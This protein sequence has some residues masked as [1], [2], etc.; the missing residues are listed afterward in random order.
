VREALSNV[1]ALAVLAS[2]VMLI[3]PLPP[4]LLDLLLAFD[5]MFAAGVLV[6]ALSIHDPLELAAFPSLLL[7]T[8]LFRLSLDVSATR[9]ILTQ[10]DVPGGVGTVIPAF[11][12]FVT[13]GNL[14][15][16]ILMLT[17]LI[18]VQLVV[19]TNGAQRVAEVAARFTLDAM[20]GKQMAIDADLH[21]GLIDAGTARQRRKAVQAEADFYGAMDGAGKFVRGDAIAAVVIVVVNVIAGTA[22]GV[23]GKHMDLAAAVATYPV[24]SVGNAL[25]TTLPAF[26]LSTAMGIMVTRAASETTLGVDLVRQLCAQ[27]HA[28]NAVG[29][30]MLALAVVPGLP[31]TAFA[32][33]GGTSLAGARLAR[34]AQRR[35][36]QAAYRI[37]EDRRRSETH[38]PEHAVSL[39]GLDV[40]S[41]H[42]GEALL[43]LL[44]PPACEELLGR[45]ALVRRRIALELGI[46]MPGV[47]VSDDLQLPARG[48]AIRLRDRTVAQGLLHPDRPLVVGAPEALT[49]I[50]GERVLDPAI[51]LQAVWPTNP[52]PGDDSAGDLVAVDP[53]AIVAT[54]LD[55]VV[56]VHAAA[57][58]GRQEVQQLLDT[59]KTAQ[60]AAVKGIVPETVSLA[61]VQRVLQHLVREEVSVRDMATII[62]TLAEEAETSRDPSRIGEAV[63][64]RLAAAI[65]AALADE[66][67]VIRAAA[68]AAGLESQV[69]AAVVP[70]D[71]GPQLG[72][73]PQTAMRLS[74]ALVAYEGRAGA[75]AVI[76]CSQ[77]LRLPLARF[78]HLC[79]TRLRVLGLAE[80]V[81]GY[82]I[83]VAETLDIVPAGDAP[84][85]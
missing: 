1:L 25:A 21:A 56:R 10:G 44:E 41:V 82:T 73:A 36:E 18:V 55:G 72:L 28:L 63:R 57:L 50:E 67:N 8:T 64:R 75:R 68:L 17:I 29:A 77:S 70:T 40:L 74:A 27:P 26:L 78:A 49:A 2:V 61:L 30:A 80:V 9:L 7:V 6:V 45:I 38:K 15:V 60:P 51:G 12:T 85:P 84:S 48:Y 4:V 23:L 34:T 35:R 54:A 53:P 16:G 32:V 69:A 43:P 47:A 33:L 65:C 52:L 5:V 66:R 58:L 24:L 11:G 71:Q 83:N 62:E 79:G 31:H 14:V 46:L 39:L 19:V 42:V 59:L 20:P 13:R 22:I 76:V 37:E 81:V 3:I